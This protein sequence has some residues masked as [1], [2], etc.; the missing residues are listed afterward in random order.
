M[1]NVPNRAVNWIALVG[2][3]NS[4]AIARKGSRRIVV[5]SIPYRWTVRPRPTYDQA[6]AQAGMSFAVALENGG[7]TTLLVKLNVVRPDNWMNKDFVPITPVV[8]EGAI[9]QAL[10][11]GWSP[12]NRGRAFELSCTLE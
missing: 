5:D 1:S 12:I 8:V 10:K 9:R 2:S 11:K 6:L 7:Q 3:P 4:M